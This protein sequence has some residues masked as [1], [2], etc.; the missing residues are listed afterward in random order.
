MLLWGSVSYSHVA[1]NKLSFFFCCRLNCWGDCKVT[2][3]T[4]RTRDEKNSGTYNATQCKSVWLHI[5]VGDAHIHELWHKLQ[6][7]EKNQQHF[8]NTFNLKN[9]V[10][11]WANISEMR[12][13]HQPNL[14]SKI[15]LTMLRT[16]NHSHPGC[17]VQPKPTAQLKYS[18][19]P[20]SQLENGIL[21]LL[22]LLL[23]THY[24][25]KQLVVSHIGWQRY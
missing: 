24:T 20:T 3:A 1:L 23:R 7:L 25:R 9:P 5:S 22:S 13:Q 21:E 2:D 6:E 16:A 8:G 11:S 12:T 17:T 19:R 10:S 4:V 18:M 14:S 15:L